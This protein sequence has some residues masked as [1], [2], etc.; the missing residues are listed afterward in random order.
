MNAPMSTVL[1]SR[2]NSFMSAT[3]R[4]F[5]RTV[6]RYF[7]SRFRS[8]IL[9][10]IFLTFM[11]VE[12][13]IGKFFSGKFT[14]H[15]LPPTQPA[16]PSSAKRRLRTRPGRRPKKIKPKKQVTSPPVQV[17]PCQP[18]TDRLISNCQKPI[19]ILPKENPKLEH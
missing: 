8:S 17:T 19:F 3:L 6:S 9:M 10:V 14:T 1:W 16:R 4:L 13:E 2:G 18:I 5:F 7:L 11:L 12:V 15:P